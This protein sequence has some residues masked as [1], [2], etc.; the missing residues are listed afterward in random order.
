MVFVNLV[1]QRSQ[2]GGVANRET[3]CFH[4]IVKLAVIQRTTAICVKLA[5]QSVIHATIRSNWWFGMSSENM[6]NDTI[7]PAR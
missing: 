1:D 2:A 6:Q 5:K 7:N 3:G 4:Q